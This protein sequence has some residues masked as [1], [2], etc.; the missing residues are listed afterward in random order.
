MASPTSPPPVTAT[1]PSA[2][3]AAATFANQDPA[4][5][6]ANPPPVT[7]KNAAVGVSPKWVRIRTRRNLDKR[8]TFYERRRELQASQVELERQRNP[9]EPLTQG[10]TSVTAWA[11]GRQ[12]QYI[13]GLNEPQNGNGTGVVVNSAEAI[14]TNWLPFQKNHDESRRIADAE[15][16]AAKWEI[17]PTIDQEQSTDTDLDIDSVGE[18]GNSARREP[19]QGRGGEGRCDGF[20][21]VAESMSQPYGSSPHSS[22]SISNSGSTQPFDARIDTS[23]MYRDWTRVLKVWE[24]SHVC[25]KWFCAAH[26]FAGIETAHRL[27]LNGM[28]AVCRRVVRVSAGLM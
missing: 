8:G 7:H 23:K 12:Q 24:V 26:W 11:N 19:S 25:W 18:G 20:D 2:G 13:Y 4:P 22:S 28:R 3:I 17:D 5:S 9:V 6:T 16:M 1:A 27:I 15:S 14:A 21:G 10:P